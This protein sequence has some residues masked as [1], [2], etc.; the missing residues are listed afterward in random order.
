MK[1]RTPGAATA[2][3][4]K[5]KP[6]TYVTI[7]GGAVSPAANYIPTIWSEGVFDA[8]LPLMPRPPKPPPPAEPPY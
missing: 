6:R 7:L 3:T 4:N 1:R 5:G 2:A 8:L